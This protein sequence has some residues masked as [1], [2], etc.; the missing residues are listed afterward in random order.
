MQVAFQELKDKFQERRLPV[1]ITICKARRAGAS[2]VVEAN[3]YHDTTFNHDTNSLIVGNQAK[4]SENVLKMCT[5]FWRST[6]EAFRPRFPASYRNNPPKDRLEFPDLN[7][8][9]FVASARSLDQ[10]LSFGFQNIHATEVAYYKDGHG[11]FRALTPTMVDSAH[12]M[13]VLES[14]PNGMTGDGAFF[15]EQV[16][17]AQANNE[18]DVWERDAVRLLFVPWHKMNLSFYLPFESDKKKRIFALELKQEERDLIKQVHG[19]EYE[20]LLWRRMMLRRAPFNSDPERF[21]QEYPTD[22]ATAFLSTGTSVFGK[23]VIK[24]LMSRVRDPIWRGDI[25]WGESDAKNKRCNISD[26]IRRPV[27]LTKGEA[28]ARGFAS[29][30]NDGLYGNLKVWRWHERGERLFICGDVGGGDPDSKD[31]DFS[32]LAIGVLNDYGQDELIMTWRGRLNPLAFGEVASALAWA[33]YIR[34]GDEVPAPT[35]AIEWNG[36]GKSCNTYIDRYNLYPHTYRYIQPGV[37]GQRPTKHIGWESNANTKPL[38]VNYTQRHCE[39]DRIDIPDHQTV[40][41][42]SCYQKFGGYGDPSDYGGK[43]GVHDDCVT[44]LEILIV[45]LRYAAGTGTPEEVTTIDELVDPRGDEGDIPFDPFDAGEPYFGDDE[46][47]EEGQDE[48]IFWT[49]R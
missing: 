25:Y 36:P 27:F 45:L 21:D 9:I 20:Q 24:R 10:Y 29:H 46:D 30:V 3:L 37:H 28:Q 44:A 26:V 2:T 41:E 19:L 17:L 12:S 1:R 47:D 11:L 6:P 34:T 48:R 23:K 35:L 39:R 13:Q 7:S 15:F 18:M 14:T 42:M 22:L 5:G 33:L 16:M 8:A 32:T 43:A 31:G 4:P 38:M 40:L 49:G